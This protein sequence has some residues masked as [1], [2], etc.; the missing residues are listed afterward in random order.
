MTDREA[1]HF[2]GRYYGLTWTGSLDAQTTDVELDDLGP[3]PER[4]CV[5]RIVF[6]DDAGTEPTF[7]QYA[8]DGL[9]LALVEK[10]IKAARDGQPLAGG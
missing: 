10:F 5:G 4:G 2:A 3:A 6:P 1:W 9:P 8:A 7:I